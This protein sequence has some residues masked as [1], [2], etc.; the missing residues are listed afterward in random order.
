MAK[1]CQNASGHL[2][3]MWRNLRKTAQNTSQNVLLANIRSQTFGL[4][5]FVGRS[6]FSHYWTFEEYFSGCCSSDLHVMSDILVYVNESSSCCVVV[7]NTDAALESFRHEMKAQVDD[8]FCCP[9][10]FTWLVN[11][12]GVTVDRKCGATPPCTSYI[13]IM[14]PATK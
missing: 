6:S 14:S 10:K 4:L 13:A 9:F 3:V 12:K 8:V 1:R 7:E 2:T 5:Q 11:S